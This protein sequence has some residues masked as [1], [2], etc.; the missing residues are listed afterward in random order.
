M[1][2]LPNS[3]IYNNHSNHHTHPPIP[4]PPNHIGHNPVTSTDPSYNPTTCT[5][6]LNNQSTDTDTLHNPTTCINTLNNTPSC[7]KSFPSPATCID[8]LQNPSTCTGTL[9]APPSN[10]DTLNDP[11]TL[12]THKKHIENCS[13]NNLIAPTRCKSEKLCDV[14]K[15]C[16]PTI[17]T[18]TRQLLSKSKLVAPSLL[19]NKDDKIISEKIKPNLPK[20]QSRK[21]H[22]QQKSNQNCL[23]SCS[24]D[25]VKAI[26]RQSVSLPYNSSVQLY[27]TLSSLYSELMSWRRTNYVKKAV[28]LFLYLL[29]FFF[30]RYWV[31]L[32]FYTFI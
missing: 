22:N 18:T 30:I 15:D 31:L 26:S 2:S 6:Q 27:D 20:P 5:D 12:Y 4:Q 9:S 14:S 23:Y 21:R 16:C 17:I 1:A 13:I 32:M 28:R 3:D 11:T 29:V 7:V 19:Y 8:A 24:E 25:N 10:T